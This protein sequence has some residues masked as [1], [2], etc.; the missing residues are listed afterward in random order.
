MF[1]PDEFRLQI[2]TDAEEVKEI[3]RIVADKLNRSKGPVRFLIP[4]Q[5]WSTLSVEGAD[6]YDPAADRVFA[7]ELRKHLKPEIEVIELDTHLN[8]PEFAK[9]AVDALDAMMQAR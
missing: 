7:P 8:T 4:M 5:G 1:F 2:R 6:L 3:A 9:A